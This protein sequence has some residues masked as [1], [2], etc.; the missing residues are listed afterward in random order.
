MRLARGRLASTAPLGFVTTERAMA[1]K[2]T[3]GEREIHDGMIE[4]ERQR[5]DDAVQ[6][7]RDAQGETPSERARRSDTDENF[8]RSAFVWTGL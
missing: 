4:Q 1:D 2:A 8:L 7:Q 5:S 6:A 3:T